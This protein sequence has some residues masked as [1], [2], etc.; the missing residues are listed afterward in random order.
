MRSIPDIYKEAHAN[1]SINSKKEREY[2]VKQSKSLGIPKV[3]APALIQEIKMELTL[4]KDQEKDLPKIKNKSFSASESRAG[5]QHQRP[6]TAP[7]YVRPETIL[8][9]FHERI[10]TKDGSSKQPSDLFIPAHNDIS[11]H[12]VS[13]EEMIR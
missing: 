9:E 2:N 3:I 13:W 5:S 4:R 11:L 7:T 10:K 6:Y 1:Y 8:S 12:K